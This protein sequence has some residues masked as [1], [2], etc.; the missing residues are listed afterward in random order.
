MALEVGQGGPPSMPSASPASTMASGTNSCASA[1]PDSAREATMPLK[2]RSR[3]ASTRFAGE[4]GVGRDHQQHAVARG[5]PPRGRPRPRRGERARVEHAA[6]ASGSPRLAVAL[7]GAGRLPALGSA[8]A[9]GS[10]STGTYSSGRYSVNSLPSP[11][12]LSTCSSPPSRR[13][14]SREID[15]PR[16]VPPYLRLVPPSP[17]WKASKISRSLSSRCPR[18]CPPPRTPRAPSAPGA[19]RSVTPPRR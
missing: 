5:R 17:C 16:P 11:G 7:G 19:R 4:L 18:R 12:V 10:G 13:A 3:A 15:R 9:I 2:P 1:M 14:I 6:A 8:G